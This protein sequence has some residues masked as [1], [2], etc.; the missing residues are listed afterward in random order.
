[1]GPPAGAGKAGILRALDQ[2]EG[3]NIAVYDPETGQPD[4]RLCWAY[5]SL[6]SNLLEQRPSEKDVVVGGVGEDGRLRRAMRRP[7]G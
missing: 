3:Q 6:W 4:D 2:E 1:M 5:A 7:G